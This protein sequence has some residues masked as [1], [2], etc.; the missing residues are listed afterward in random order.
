[1]RAASAQK[2]IAFSLPLG[3]F[4]L[5]MAVAFALRAALVLLTVP[6]ISGGDTPGLLQYGLELVRNQMLL[7]P[8]IPP[9]YLLYTGVV[10]SVF[11]EGNLTIF[12]LLNVLWSTALVGAVFIAAEA[13]FNRRVAVIAAWLIAINPIFI[14]EAGQIL[15]ESVFLPLMFSALAL[16]GRY[17]QRDALMTKRHAVLVGVLLGLASL[18]RAVALLLPV[19]L[20]AHLLWR[21]RQRAPRLIAALLIAYSATVLTWTVYGYLR[22]RTIMIGGSGLAANFYLGTNE[23]W[24]GPQCIDER[25]GVTV[26]DQGRNDEIYARRAI[27]TILSDPLGYL[28]RRAT[29]LL[30]ASLQPHNTNLFQGES[31]RA[32]VL[33]WWAHDRSLAGLSAV[34]SGDAFAPKL[35]LYIFHIG[36]LLLGALGLLFSA[37]RRRMFGQALPLYGALGYFYALHSI[38]TAIPRYLFPTAAL[39]LI[40]ASTVLAE[41]TATESRDEQTAQSL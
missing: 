33:Q 8:P 1:M 32:L 12:R 5:I 4:V 34:L 15:T 21:Y 3:N 26:E 40:F 18:T 25:A 22:W 29:N 30:E 20:V 10:Q 41:R 11:G 13:Y 6:N 17:T 39:W 23:G 38:L 36:A 9:L 27:E 16:H 28:V 14:V 35:L 2:H 19:I 37:F 7:M 31:L 24:C